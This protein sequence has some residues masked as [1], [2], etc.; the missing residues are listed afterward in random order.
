MDVLA[1]LRN[2]RAVRE[3][4]GR[5]LEPGHLHAILEAG[6]ASPSS[7]NE[8]RWRFVAVTDPERL[9]ELARVGDY[10]DHLAGAGAGIALVHPEAR[11]A[12]QRESI[13]FDLGQVA[14]S[15]MLAAWD[16]GIGSSH[17]S[18]YDEPRTRELLAIPAGWHCDVILSLGYPADPGVI[19]RGRS[20][21]A[22]RPLA[23]TVHEERWAGG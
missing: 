3:F 22:R 18:V 11:E 14:Q 23:E 6:A 4:D 5:P 2:Q 10:A 1:A 8:Q 12:W 16:L 19:T 15:M 21:E 13:A 7:M 9:G 17:A 20:T